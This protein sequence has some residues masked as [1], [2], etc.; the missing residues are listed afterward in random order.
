MNVRPIRILLIDDHP[1]VLA[2]YRRLIETAPDMRVVAE[3]CNGEDGYF[4]H[5][6][7][8]PDVVVLDLALPGRSGLDTLQRILMRDPAAKVL[9]VSIHDHEAF[10]RRAREGGARGF[11]SK[12]IAPEVLLEAVRR[13]A[14]GE[15]FFPDRNGLD[16]GAVAVPFTR[17]S[18]REFEVF[19]MLADGHTV[20]Q[21]S[22]MLSISPKT[23]AVH[24]TRIMNKLDLENLAQ[25]TRLAIRHGIIQP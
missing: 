4:V 11:L 7:H 14:L 8:N 2:G 19:R 3:A 15:S 12:N 5:F 22:R 24:Q 25:L 9:V 13:I 10:V 6:V 18:P 17:L 23:A 21:I 1:V 20:A 16:A